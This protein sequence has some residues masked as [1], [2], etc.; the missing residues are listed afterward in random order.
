[1][2]ATERNLNAEKE[3]EIISNNSP[4]TRL[5]DLYFLARKFDRQDQGKPLVYTGIKRLARR[6][7]LSRIVLDHP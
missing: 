2:K 5:Q 1:M 6:M 4:Q 3:E 7:N